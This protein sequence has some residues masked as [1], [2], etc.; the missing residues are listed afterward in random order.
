MY[1]C[2]IFVVNIILPICPH[3][4]YIVICTNTPLSLY[5]VNKIRESGDHACK[6][7]LPIVRR[8]Y[9]KVHCIMYSTVYI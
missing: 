2:Y 3:S 5:C 4:Q 9:C 1:F 6:K 7:T 8:Q